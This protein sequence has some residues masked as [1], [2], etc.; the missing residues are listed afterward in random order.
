MIP[1]QWQSRPI[2]RVQGHTTIVPAC[3]PTYSLAGG[4]IAGLALV[5]L[6][7]DRV[8]GC[9]AVCLVWWGAHSMAVVYRA[10][11][12]SAVLPFVRCLLRFVSS[13]SALRAQYCLPSFLVIEG[14]PCYMVLLPW[15]W[16]GRFA[17]C[18]FGVAHGCLLW[19][20]FVERPRYAPSPLRR[21]G[22]V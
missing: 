16:D 2:Q 18:H 20:F 15:G 5:L 22:P 12:R 21:H 13:T 14:P 4:L 9:C 6:P 8:L 10:R 17:E 19:C 7:I 3:R 1:I 11:W